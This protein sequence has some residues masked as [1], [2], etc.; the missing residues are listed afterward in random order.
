MGETVN[1]FR[2]L[3]RHIPGE[4]SHQRNRRTDSE[5]PVAVAESPFHW[6]RYGEPVPSGGRVLLVGVAVWNGYDLN[7]LDHAE[8]AVRAGPAVGTE[9]FVF[10]AHDLQTDEQ[11]AALLPGV[12]SGNQTPFVGLFSHGTPVETAGGCLGRQ[13]VARTL[14]FDDAPLHEPVRATVSST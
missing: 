6:W 7:T 13:L 3:L 5:L 10:D 11:L 4:D 12:Y 9:V 8:S 14:N 1:R 2:H